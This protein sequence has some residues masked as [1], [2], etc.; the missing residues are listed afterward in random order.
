MCLAAIAL[1]PAHPRFVFVVAANRDEFHD[2]PTAPLAWWEDDRDIL[3]GRDLQAGGSWLGLSRSGRFALLT[4]VRAPS[5]AESG[6]PSRGTLVADWLQDNT[7]AQT[8]WAAQASLGHRPYNLI[9]ADLAQGACWWMN[10]ELPAPQRMDCGL[11]GLSNAQLDTPWPKVQVLKQRVADAMAACADAG[12]LAQRLFAALTDDALSDDAELPHTGV[13]LDLE[14]ALSAAF[15]RAPQRGYGTRCSTVVISAAGS[16][17]V[18]ERSYARDGTPAATRHEVLPGWPP[19][20]S[21]RTI[22]TCGMPASSNA[23]PRSAKPARA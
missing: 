21:A 4:N 7:G 9:A 22:S 3:A 13:P 17:H 16:T 19:Q 5:A 10:P 15:I 23:A 20:T 18:W 2:R 1:G 6:A 8:F 14:R 12:Q 11:H